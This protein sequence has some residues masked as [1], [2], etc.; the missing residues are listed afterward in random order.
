MKITITTELDITAEDFGA[1]TQA[2]SKELPVIADKTC[3]ENR[4]A[5]LQQFATYDNYLREAGI[6]IDSVPVE[7]REA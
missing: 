6:I 5:F 2:L 1:L 3:G 4:T 7:I